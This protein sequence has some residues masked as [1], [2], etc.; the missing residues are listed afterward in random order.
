MRKQAQN[1]QFLSCIIVQHCLILHLQQCSLCTQDIDIQIMITYRAKLIFRSHLQQEGQNIRYHKI[2][3]HQSFMQLN[4]FVDGLP[5]CMLLQY[6]AQHL[7]QQPTRH[8]FTMNKKGMRGTPQLQ[9]MLIT[10]NV[11]NLLSKLI[12]VMDLIRKQHI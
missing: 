10:A 9:Q 12:A 7:S 5:F 1:E 2:Q 6:Y 3:R 4:C 11:I 8:I